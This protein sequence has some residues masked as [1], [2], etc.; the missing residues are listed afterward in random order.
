MLNKPSYNELEWKVKDIEDVLS[1]KVNE[2]DRLKSSILANISHEIRTPMNSI[3]GFSNLLSESH[4]TNDQ[5]VFFVSE[6]NKSSKELLRLIDNILL[7]AKFESENVLINNTE[8]NIAK[9]LDDL[10][11]HF[12]LK[13]KSNLESKIRVKLVKPDNEKTR[14]VYTDQ[15]KI[16]KV[17]NNLIENAIKYTSNGTVEFG[18]SITPVSDLQFF[19]KDT[20]IGI[21]QDDFEKI[22]TEFT[23]LDSKDFRNLNG[24]G[25]GL[26]IS[27]RLVGLL[28]G[29]LM[30]N[31][32]PGHG[33]LFSFILPNLVEKSA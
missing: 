5:K 20:G 8:C 24:L 12:N 22:H 25:L 6:I 16:K 4:F 15:K 9:V 23:Q 19:V 31:S 14:I 21:A 10:F 28:G 33:S 1:K 32:T 13:V 7:T 11:F 27:N 17:L 18:Y 30:V 29:K 3:V 2:V 26:T